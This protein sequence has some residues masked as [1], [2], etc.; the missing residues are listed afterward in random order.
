MR[1]AGRVGV[2][3][4]AGTS[5]RTCLGGWNPAPASVVGKLFWRGVLERLG[6]GDG[7]LDAI[8]DSLEARDLVRHEPT[9]LVRRIEIG[10]GIR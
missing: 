1:R 7:A 2:L 8:L 10:G 4:P 3:A 9:R 5:P 6:S